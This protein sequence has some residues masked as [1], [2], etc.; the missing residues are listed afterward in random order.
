VRRSIGE[1]GATVNETGSGKP[2]HGYAPRAC[3]IELDPLREL[4]YRPAACTAAAKGRTHVSTRP[5]SV[6]FRKI[7]LAPTGASTHVHDDDVAWLK[8]R[9]E[10]LLN[11]GAE[12][13]AVDWAVEQTR[14]G[15]TV[16][17]QG[18]KESQRPPVAVWREAPHPL[19]FLPPSA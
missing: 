2:D 7:L 10:N 18:A 15:E 8:L 19:A 4:P 6:A 12:A 5:S 17:A 11:I 14:S 3:E 9:N 16:A 1:Y 13:F